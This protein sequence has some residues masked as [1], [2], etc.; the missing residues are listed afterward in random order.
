MSTFSPCCI[1]EAAIQ[2]IVRG[3]R[4]TGAAQMVGDNGVALGRLFVDL[5]DPHAGRGQEL[6]QD[7]AVTLFPA[8]AAEPGEQ[9][10]EDDGIHDDLVC[11]PQGEFDRLVPL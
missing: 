10:T 11:A 6:A 5:H 4:R 8:A 7:I 1:A 2:K 9:F 3:D